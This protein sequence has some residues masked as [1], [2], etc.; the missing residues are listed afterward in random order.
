MK[1]LFNADLVTIRSLFTNEYNANDR[2]KNYYIPLYQREYNWEK[3]HILKLFEDIYK[4]SEQNKMFQPYFLG[5]IVFSRQSMEGEER[6]SISLEVIDGQQRLTTLSI[7]IALIIQSL[8]FEGRKFK[9][10]EDFIKDLTEK[11]ISYVITKRFDKDY[12]VSTVLK[13]ERSDQLQETYE[14]VIFNLINKKIKYMEYNYLEG[15]NKR[16]FNNV[17]A[18]HK[19]I[20]DL[21]ENDLIHFTLQL[22]DHTEMVVTKTDSFET[23]YLVF[24]K[25]NDSGKGLSA[26]DLLK[27]YLFSIRKKEDDTIEIKNRWEELIEIIDS[28]EPKLTPKDFLEFYLIITGNEYKSST[29]TTDIFAGYKD[30][31]KQNK[32]DNI[33]VL[34]N[35][36]KVAN[37]LTLLK[38]DDYAG[39]ILNEIGFKLGFLVFLSFYNRYSNEFDSFEK[40]IFNLL[41]RLG[42]ILLITNDLKNIKKIVTNISRNISREEDSDAN[43]TYSRIKENIENIILEKKDDFENSLSVENRFK[44]EHFT[45]ILFN[46]INIESDLPKLSTEIVLERIMPE[47]IKNSNYD[48]EG[49]NNDNLNK[50]SN[51]LGNL[52]LYDTNERNLPSDFEERK[53]LICINSENII[54]GIFA[55]TTKSKFDELNQYNLYT[56]WDKENITKRTN[57]LTKIAIDFFIYNKMNTDK[58]F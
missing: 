47:D 53:K 13:V 12:K 17:K 39:N 41:F 29:T 28:I 18:L 4:L 2:D 20:K 34:D 36:I 3:K 25:L 1:K 27:N 44:R 52:I 23:G 56:K 58:L 48:F 31:F 6:S 7:L 51:M 24:E 33:S 46:L 49:I 16:F 30:Y 45:I 54:N 50:Y 42:Y 8:K 9:G 15:D 57:C 14:A 10:K 37:K 43:I 35:M 19:L 32:L 26:H 21:D 22:L 5:G 11:L 40:K 38:R 55:N